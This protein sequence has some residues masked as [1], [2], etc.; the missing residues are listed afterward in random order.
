M[1]RIWSGSDFGFRNSMMVPLD[2]KM[3]FNHI[4]GCMSPSRQS[5][6]QPRLWFPCFGEFEFLCDARNLQWLNG[7]MVGGNRCCCRCEQS[8]WAK[9][10]TV[11]G[12]SS[13]RV[14]CLTKKDHFIVLKCFQQRWILSILNSQRCF[15]MEEIHL[16][17]ICYCGSF[18]W[19]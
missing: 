5:D 13:K 17:A 1:A 12:V 16:S 2:R 10:K 4:L 11:Q 6:M 3:S 9:S 15:V 8:Y 7:T 14:R 19:Q 18:V